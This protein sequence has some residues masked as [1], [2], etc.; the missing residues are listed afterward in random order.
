MGYFFRANPF[1]F[2]FSLLSKNIFNDRICVYL[3]VET[4]PRLD[5]TLAPPIPSK[6][7]LLEELVNGTSQV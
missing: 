1:S 2:F 4:V 3:Q 6:L 7:G 5:L